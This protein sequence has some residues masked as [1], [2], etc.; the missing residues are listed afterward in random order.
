[1]TI[2][3]AAASTPVSELDER[4]LAPPSA[5]PLSGPIMTRG[6]AAY[7]SEEHGIVSGIWESEPG[8]SRWTFEDRGEFIFVVSGRMTVT[9]DGEDAVELTPGD[10]AIFPVGWTGTWEVHVT[11]RKSFVV[12]QRSRS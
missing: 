2:S 3:F 7:V 8:L 11:L 1:M 5:Q 9:E 12:F 6:K 10:S 4:P